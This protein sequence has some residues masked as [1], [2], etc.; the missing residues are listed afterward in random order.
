MNNPITLSNIGLAGCG[1]M[2]QPMLEG[3][4]AGDFDASGFDIK[5]PE[6]YGAFAEA[7]TDDPNK[8]GKSLTILITVV[9]DIEQTND[10]LFGRQ[11]FV[12]LAKN[13]EYIVVSS[14]LSPRYVKALR[15]RIPGH[16]KLVDA[17]M[18][19]A[20]VAAKIGH[21]SFMLGGSNADLDALQPLFEAMGKSLHR[22]GSF[23]AGMTAKVLNNLLAAS[24]TAMTRLVL[25]WADDLGL[26]EEKL[27][28]LMEQSS[29]QNW[30]ASGFNDIEFARDGYAL[31]NSIGILE[32]DVRSALNAAQ[33][34]ADTAL[35][36]A[37]IEA[38]RALKPRT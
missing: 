17:P 32:K 31:D 3:L 25:D 13:L 30:F 37:V 8:F 35:P 21:L 11:N 18:S 38:I 16:I 6:S 24:S 2:G 26:E 1:R 7:M 19:G 22:M 36:E 14:T 4:R 27:L 10:V 12:S 20:T 29:G 28:A 33:S 5:P 23:G 9:R 34:G 15:D